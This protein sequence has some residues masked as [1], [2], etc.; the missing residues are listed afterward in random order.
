M[1]Q[2]F[3]DAVDDVRQAHSLLRANGF[4]MPLEDAGMSTV[5]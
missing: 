3:K 5:P 2:S 4:R 1:P